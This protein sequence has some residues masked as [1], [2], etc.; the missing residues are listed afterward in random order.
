ML[1]SPNKGETAVH[2]C[3][4]PG[5]MAM[6]VRGVLPRPWVGVCKPL[7]LSLSYEKIRLLPLRL[8]FLSCNDQLPAFCTQPL[9]AI[10]QSLV[11][12]VT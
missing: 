4:C 7:A 1:V 11:L 3:H 8:I 6:R 5:D 10:S 9:L 12:A 2:G